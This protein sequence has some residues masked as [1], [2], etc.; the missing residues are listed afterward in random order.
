MRGRTDDPGDLWHSEALL[1]PSNTFIVPT[2]S[3][4]YLQYRDKIDHRRHASNRSWG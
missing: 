4:A 3:E 2:D 1:K